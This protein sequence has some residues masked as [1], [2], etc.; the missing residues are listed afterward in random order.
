MQHEQD[1][2]GL[3]RGLIRLYQRTMAKTLYNIRLLGDSRL[4]DSAFEAFLDG[5]AT[6]IDVD[7]ICYRPR[8]ARSAE[9]LGGDFVRIANDAN[10]AIARNLKQSPDDER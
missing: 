3:W 7:P 4:R 1:S 8:R 2:V 10:R 5:Y 6:S 9:A